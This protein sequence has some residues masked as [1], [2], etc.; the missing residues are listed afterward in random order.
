MGRPNR[1]S[2][3]VRERAVRMVLEHEREYD[4]KWTAM[5][6]IASKI[7]CAAETLRNWFRQAARD[8]GNRPRLTTDGKQR[9]KD[10]EREN[11][12][13]KRANEVLRKASLEME[14]STATETGERALLLF[15][16]GI[17]SVLSW[18]A[19]Q[20]SGYRVE[21][22]TVNYHGRPEGE[23]QAC[24]HLLGALRCR[25]SHRLTLDGW[26]RL[27]DVSPPGV[28]PELRAG[29]IPY[30][31]LVFWSLAASIAVRDGYSAVAAGHTTEDAQYFND[32]S[33]SFFRRLQELLTFAGATEVDLKLLLPLSMLPDEGTSLA[34]TIPWHQLDRSWS[35]WLNGPKPCRQCFACRERDEFLAEVR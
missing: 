13:L 6:S 33:P 25:R 14:S 17:D 29:F 31:N 3:G 28:L 18:H 26:G 10:L 12:E 34:R 11:R 5:V 19:L 35:C 23:V 32:S 8:L 7:G 30:R 2:P 20:Q 15:S 4:S 21:T 27:S 16:G 22:L 1:Y 24:D 9:L